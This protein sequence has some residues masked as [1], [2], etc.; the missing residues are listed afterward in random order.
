MNF[1][2]ILDKVYA[3]DSGWK[4]TGELSLNEHWPIVLR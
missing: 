4:I 3:S 2:D 1:D